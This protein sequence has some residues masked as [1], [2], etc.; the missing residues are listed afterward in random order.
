MQ[1][2]ISF[3]DEA[4]APLNPRGVAVGLSGGADS[5]ALA[6]LAQD[7]CSQHNVTFAA[8]TVDHRLRVE[9]AAEAALVQAECAKRNIPHH[10]LVW[11]HDGV[12]TRKQERAR[13]ARYDLMGDWCATNNFSV[14]MTA[15]HADDQAETVLLRLCKGSGAAGLA[16]IAPMRPLNDTVDLL[17]PL[18]PVTKQQLIDYAQAHNVPIVEDPSNHN[19]AY[20]RARLRAARPIL[21]LEG[22]TTGN[23]L[24]LAATAREEQDAL[25]YAADTL[26]LQQGEETDSSFTLPAQP[27]I[28]APVA[29]RRMAFTMIWRRLNKSMGYPPRREEIDDLTSALATPGTKRTLG[30]LICAHQKDKLVFT[31][32]A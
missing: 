30:G 22:L 17:R 26:L 18:L 2:L 6:L 15:H 10:T 13:A 12:D 16:G 29:L 9:G 32:E 25:R 20:A 19:P 8:L 23:L 24:K 3:I 27:W 28:A 21:E 11:Q 5:W 4:L 7:W 31:R 14:L 1:E